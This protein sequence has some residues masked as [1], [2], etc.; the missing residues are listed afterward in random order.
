MLAETGNAGA[1]D[2]AADLQDERIHLLER[3]LS[4]GKLIARHR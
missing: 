4:R 3:P 1:K 2:R